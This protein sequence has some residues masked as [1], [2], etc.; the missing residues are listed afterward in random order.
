MPMSKWHSIRD[1]TSVCIV[2]SSFNRQDKVRDALQKA[3]SDQLE[4]LASMRTFKAGGLDCE[5]TTAFIW[6]LTY[7]PLQPKLEQIKLIHDEDYEKATFVLDCTHPVSFESCEVIV[8]RDPSQ[9]SAKKDGIWR[10]VVEST[11]FSMSAIILRIL[12]ILQYLICIVGT[13]AYGKP[14]LRVQGVFLF[15]EDTEEGPVAYLGSDVC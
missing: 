12:P 4:L 8:L 2:C 5:W 6:L 7:S 9:D 3:D 15:H 11:M 10:R 13:C 14:V 1:V